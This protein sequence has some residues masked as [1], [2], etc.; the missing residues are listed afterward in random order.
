MRIVSLA[1]AATEWLA[2]FG[3]L[4]ELV[5]R[6]HACDQPAVADLPVLTRPSIDV[7]GSPAEIDASVRAAVAAGRPVVQVDFERLS[8]L[9][10]DVVVVQDSCETCTASGSDVSAQLTA[11]GVDVHTFSPRTFKQVL[12][13]ALTLAGRIGRMPRAMAYIA[14]RERA[15][16]Q[17]R[18]RLGV[19]RDGTIDGVPGPRVACVEWTQPLILAGHWTPDLVEHV[20]AR[21]V[22][23]ASGEASVPSNLEALAGADVLVVTPCGR[24]VGQ[25]AADADALSL[26]RGW[27]S[28]PSVA[29]GRVVLGDGQAR[30]HRPGPGL[31]RTIQLLAAAVHGQKAG[32]APASWELRPWRSE[33]AA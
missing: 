20:G 4:P 25:A 30:F 32:I 2:A 18:D 19:R 28:L 31:Y 10:P 27:E 7:E 21:P 13:A 29:A 22:G 23:P 8:A 33:V 16:Q 5:G 12:E 9:Q 26:V 11:Q 14:E 1:P 15:L 17:L 6:S 24:T 3:A